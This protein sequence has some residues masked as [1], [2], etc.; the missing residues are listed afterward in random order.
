M[1]PIQSKQLA[2]HLPLTLQMMFRLI[3]D[4]AKQPYIYELAYKIVDTVPDR[5]TVSPEEQDM[6]EI[7]AIWEWVVRNIRYTRDPWDLINNRPGEKLAD[8][9]VTLRLKQGDCDDHCI[10]T[11]ALLTTLGHRVEIWVG[12]YKRPTHVFLVAYTASGVPV[13]V[14]TTAKAKP[15]GAY[16]GGPQWKFWKWG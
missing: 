3:C 10:L 16:P 14:D 12:G 6:A 9:E 4:G 13:V 5:A 2:D 11:G 1:R 8:V 7:H 15:F